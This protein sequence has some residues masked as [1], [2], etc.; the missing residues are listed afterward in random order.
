MYG[1]SSQE[2]SDQILERRANPEISKVNSMFEDYKI[3]AN[4]TRFQEKAMQL[5]EEDRVRDEQIEEKQLEEIM[6]QK[7]IIEQQKKKTKR[8]SSAERA[9][10]LAAQYQKAKEEREKLAAESLQKTDLPFKQAPKKAM[11]VMGKQKK[12]LETS[13]DYGES[14]KLRELIAKQCK[15]YKAEV[16]EKYP[17][18]YDSSIMMGE[19]DTKIKN[20]ILRS[21]KYQ[22]M[23]KTKLSNF[24]RIE[25]E[26]L[27]QQREIDQRQLLMNPSHVSLH[28]GDAEA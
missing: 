8:M 24:I 3:S 20:E 13:L 22:K 5:I 11:I 26:K 15:I 9:R 2:V 19:E 1:K 16:N 12:A 14:A 23:K 18:D 21:I 7:N 17:D 10:D 27:L 25:R 6:K 4:Y 28:S